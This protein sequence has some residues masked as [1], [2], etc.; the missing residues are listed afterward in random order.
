MREKK[1]ELEMK[2]SSWLERMDLTSSIQTIPKKKKTNP[3]S[4]KTGSKRKGRK[5]KDKGKEDEEEKEEEEGNDDEVDI[6]NDFSREMH[7]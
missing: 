1:L 2:H 3:S 5:D 4:G 7:L 6:E